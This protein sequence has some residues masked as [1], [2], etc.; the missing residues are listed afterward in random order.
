MKNEGRP[1]Q[2]NLLY[3]TRFNSE[4][5]GK[6]RVFFTCHPEDFELF[7]EDTV[8]MLLKHVNCV[9]WYDGNEETGS[10]TEA[11][12]LLSQIEGMQLIVIPV[13][14]RL[15]TQPCRAMDIILPFARQKKIAV[16]PLMMETD[17]EKL[18]TERFGALQFLEPYGSD[19]TAISFD[20]KLSRYL[21]SVLVGDDVAQKI[22]DAFDAYIFL[23]YRKKDRKYAQELMRMI[24]RN[25]HYRDIAIW[26]DEFLVPGENFNES[27]RTYLER[28]DLFAMVVTPS[29]LE[30]PN[31]VWEHEF[32][33]AQK[34][35]KKILP[36]EMAETDT[37]QLKENYNGIP[38][39]IDGSRSEEWSQALET[40]L[41]EMALSVS[42]GDAQH[43]FLIGLAYLDGIDVEVDY[44]K[45]LA[46][47]SAAA[48]EDLPEACQKLVSMYKTGKGV[49]LDYMAA[50][51]WQK[52]LISYYENHP[53]KHLFTEH[54]LVRH[55]YSEM[56]GLLD[57]YSDLGDLDEQKKICEKT[58]DLLEAHGEF[59][60]LLF[61]Y[62]AAG[63]VERELG[64]LYMAA[65]YYNKAVEIIYNNPK[66]ADQQYRYLPLFEVTLGDIQREL[67]QTK[68]AL[69]FYQKAVQSC[70]DLWHFEEFYGSKDLNEP[71][72]LFKE[73]INERFLKRFFD[74][75][76]DR[77][78]ALKMTGK[79]YFK[80]AESC[81]ELSG[82]DPEFKTLYSKS[83]QC[84]M[85]LAIES[86]LTE[87]TREMH[88]CYMLLGRMWA[89]I[90]RYGTA[91]PFF[92]K[93]LEISLNASEKTK[94]VPDLRGAANSYLYLGETEDSFWKFGHISASGRYYS[95]AMNM[96]QDLYQTTGS[97]AIRMDIEKAE[98]VIT[99]AR[100]ET[101]RYV[102]PVKMSDLVI[103]DGQSFLR[104][105]E[106]AEAD[107]ND[108]AAMTILEDT[109]RTT[110]EPL[111][112][113]K[114]DYFDAARVDLHG[115]EPRT[116]LKFISEEDFG[117]YRFLLLP[118]SDSVVY[119]RTDYCTFVISQG[120]DR[121]PMIMDLSEYG[122]EDAAEITDIGYSQKDDTLRIMVHDPSSGQ[123][124][125]I[126]AG[127]S[128]RQ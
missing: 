59:Y 127:D 18:F 16:L 121:L 98:S 41:Q 64:N 27:I 10:D 11:E 6:P 15:L 97:P 39:C 89:G 5:Y 61:A 124:T 115:G 83:I 2:Y 47:I 12:A 58:V 112:G 50:A 29:L 88:E 35:G 69:E 60:Y 106:P 62:P 19:L 109:K 107:R 9:V 51:R 32:R 73:R 85:Q 116:I 46:L 123:K 120:R 92:E 77:A 70:E 66:Y 36:V 93:A 117:R 44:E 102:Q 3:R 103:S 72:Y 33:M 113:R 94:A 99:R 104:A 1:N 26:Y 128:L 114:Y 45:A 56:L 30:I 38:D 40:K 52:K 37:D 17:L 13:S 86:E 31:Y 8:Q 63:D 76:K 4:P 81:K 91:K 34:G 24:H 68:K 57:I 67:G 21:D 95:R 48:E 22:R 119:W 42:P 110:A 55:L 96:L 108:N 53:K 78:F 84:Y 100:E 126:I 90:R 20:E 75:T 71:F 74:H 65:E 49:G 101:R 105:E 7:F 25:P 28:S 118:D 111:T 87:R 14:R 125:V 82:E 79:S 43:T 54:S 80:L 122:F 23:S